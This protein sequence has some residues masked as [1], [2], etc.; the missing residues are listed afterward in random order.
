MKKI[1]VLLITVLVLLLGISGTVYAYQDIENPDEKDA[2][3]VM[4]SLGLMQAH[5]EDQFSKNATMTR[6]EFATLAV[7]MLGFDQPLLFN[8]FTIFPDVKNTSVNAPYINA[9]VR[10]YSILRGFPDGTFRPEDPITF[11]QAIT[12][13]INMLGYT[14]QDVGPFWPENYLT[15]ASNLGLSSGLNMDVN[16]PLPRSSAALLSWN[17]LNTTTKS[18]SPFLNSLYTQALDNVILLRTWQSSSAL[19]KGRAEFSV[20]GAIQQYTVQNTISPS[21]IGSRGRLILNPKSPGSALGFLP[22]RSQYVESTLIKVYADRVELASGTYPISRSTPLF[23]NGQITTFQLGWYNLLPDQTVRLYYDQVGSLQMI[24]VVSSQSITYTFIYDVNSD[25]RIP[26]DAVVYKNGNQISARIIKK[27]D[28]VS[29][30][31]KNGVYYVSDMKLK[32]YYQSGYPVYTYP[33]TI[34]VFNNTFHVDET[35]AKSFERLRLQQQIV[36]LFDNSGNIAG[37]FPAEEIPVTLYGVLKSISG[38]GS[39]SIELLGGLTVQG[40]SNMSSYGPVYSPYQGYVNEL[41]MNQGQL[42]TV[43]QNYNTERIN[44][45][46]LPYTGK[47]MGDWTVAEKKLGEATVADTVKIFE[48][49]TADAP[50]VPIYLSDIPF[51]IVKGEQIRYTISDSSGQ[52]VVVVLADVSGKGWEYGM[53]TVQPVEETLLDPLG[54]PYQAITSYQL[55][56]KQAETTLSYHVR[57]WPDSSTTDPVKVPQGMGRPSSYQN[58]LLETL[59]KYATVG[60]KHFDGDRGLNMGS[61]YLRFSP[62]MQI[63]AS[64]TRKF[65]GLPE[66]RA[67]FSTF[68]VYLDRPLEQ[69]GQVIFMTVK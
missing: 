22:D 65:I 11:A 7:K 55:T 4:S 35:A 61:A 19:L 16:Q 43:S 34:T 47:T 36:L 49:V 67:N 30:D 37:A 25:E 63:Y 3:E 56:V 68:V 33:E 57:Y 46:P 1:M 12:V 39:S 8:T 41:L 38:D 69:G 42:V 10:K 45:T 66:A 48:K 21:F 17:M 40:I 15:K 51:E 13:Y 59:E 54:N 60:Q 32:G 26:A 20:N 27:Y 2:A 24:S 6:G 23:I 50:L 29:Y 58:F 18:G 31:G 62:D 52:V 64:L 53:L 14:I 9:A 44:I 5:S 28:V